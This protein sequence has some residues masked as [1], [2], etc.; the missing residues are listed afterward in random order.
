VISAA[1][2]CRNAGLKVE[3]LVAGAGELSVKLE[4]AAAQSNVPLHALG[5]RNQTQMPEVYSACDMLVLPSTGRETW[6]LVANEALACGRPIIISDACGCAPD[7][8]ADGIAGK[9]Y[10]TTNIEALSR[11]VSEFIDA[12]PASSAFSTLSKRYSLSAAA[13]GILHALDAILHQ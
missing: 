13:D 11:C 2:L 1:A 12:P 9:I 3:V 4:Q 8:A 7:L 6:G 10:R 5:F